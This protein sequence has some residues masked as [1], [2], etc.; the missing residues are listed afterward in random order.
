[1]QKVDE[2]VLHSNIV[3]TYLCK[4]AV[5]SLTPSLQNS[6]EIKIISLG[7]NYS[8]NIGVTFIKDDTVIKMAT[9]IL[10]GKQIKHF[11]SLKSLFYDKTCFF[12]KYKL[13]ERL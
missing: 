5:S 11:Y 13:Q 12:G 6:N 8:D 4:T 10:T 2:F 7:C 3:Y 9:C 1:M